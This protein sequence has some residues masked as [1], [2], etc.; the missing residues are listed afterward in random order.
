MS[1]SPQLVLLVSSITP[2]TSMTF[3]SVWLSSWSNT[4]LQLT[5][6]HR[7]S[8][9]FRDYCDHL[10]LTSSCIPF[11]AQLYSSSQ[12]FRPQANLASETADITVYR[13]SFLSKTLGYASFLNIFHRTACGIPTTLSK[14]EMQ[15]CQ[16][17]S[18]DM[19]SFRKQARRSLYQFISRVFF[20]QRELG[21]TRSLLNTFWVTS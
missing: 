16:H 20:A 6:Q 15:Q 11:T 14:H 7:W 12:R 9:L 13:L 10:S 21:K 5:N 17:D 1:L 18:G 8:T 2:L 3:G 4:I 19:G